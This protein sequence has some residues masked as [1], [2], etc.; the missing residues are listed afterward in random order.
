MIQ[1][2]ENAS[3][4][5]VSWC[6]GW[7]KEFEDSFGSLENITQITD[8][9]T[10]T[11]EQRKLFNQ[12]YMAIGDLVKRYEPLWSTRITRSFFSVIS[13][14]ARDLFNQNIEPR[15]LESA[16]REVVH[17]LFNDDEIKA[18]QDEL[19]KQSEALTAVELMKNNMKNMLEALSSIIDSGDMEQAKAFIEDSDFKTPFQNAMR[20]SEWVQMYYKNDIKNILNVVAIEAMIDY[21]EL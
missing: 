11:P 17:L 9:E 7:K 8:P 14:A 16:T 5:L 13:G 20:D 1:S 19:F 6:N 10:I 12:L 18:I 21:F 15:R 3:E 2:F 4:A